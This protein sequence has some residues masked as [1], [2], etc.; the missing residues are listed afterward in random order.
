MLVRIV[1]LHFKEEHIAAF[2]EI[3]ESTSDQIRNFEGC[4]HL[5]GYQQGNCPNVFFTYSH[6]V[7]EAALNSYRSSDF[8]K[9]VWGKTKVL[10]QEKPQAWSLNKVV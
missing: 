6:W 3:L 8:F 1:K 4:L 9:S 2:K 7:N 10:F 5:E